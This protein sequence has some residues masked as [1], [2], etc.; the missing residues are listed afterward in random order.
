[1]NDSINPLLRMWSH[2]HGGRV[3]ENGCFTS[4]AYVSCKEYV[5]WKY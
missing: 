3:A 1:V 2:Q 4:G 5:I